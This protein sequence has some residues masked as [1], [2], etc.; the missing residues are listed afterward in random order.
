VENASVRR[1]QLRAGRYAADLVTS[2]ARE[3]VSFHV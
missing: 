1:E 3:N 2:V